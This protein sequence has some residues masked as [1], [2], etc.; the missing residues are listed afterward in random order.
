MSVEVASDVVEAACLPRLIRLAPNLVGA[1][2]DVMKMLPAAHMV[3]EAI[4][5]GRIGPG[6]TVIDTTSGTFGLGLAMVCALRGLRLHL[7]SDP[8]VEGFL[9]QRLMDL[10]AELTVVRE[11]AAD[12]GF[13]AARLAVVEQL[14]A[15]Y[16]DHFVPS[17][18]GNVNNPLAYAAVAEQIAQVVGDVA[19][20]V[21]PVGSGGSMCGTARALRSVFPSL[22]AVGVDTHHSR[23]FGQ[24]DGP[25]LLRGLG[26]SLLPSNLDHTV[27][28]EVHWVDASPA[29]AATRALHRQHALY[30]GP[31]SGAAYLVAK[32]LARRRE[33]TVVTLLPD[34]GHRYEAT[35]YD[36]TWL[37]GVCPDL[38]LDDRLPT[39]PEM[40]TAVPMRG[41]GWQAMAWER[42]SLHDVLADQDGKS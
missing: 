36:N 8:A 26:N 31:T 22:R 42:R 21:G 5:E 35:V 25:R 12:G 18:Y 29:Y 38:R 28:D 41:E 11:P 1:A 3:D 39:D 23:L 33:G 10:G 37:A 4:R 34:A 16:P 15:R 13:Q 30:M 24:Q 40:V 7:V 14:C 20:L 17:Q 9:A 27:F 32:H 19:Y 6:T 2:F